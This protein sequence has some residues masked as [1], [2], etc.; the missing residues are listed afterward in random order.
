MLH[1]AYCKPFRKRPLR[2]WLTSFGT[3][4]HH[5]RVRWCMNSDSKSVGVVPDA[6]SL[7]PALARSALPYGRH[8]TISEHPVEI[9]RLTECC[10]SDLG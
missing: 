5:E 7:W 3:L 6:M 1:T 9:E 2:W 10:D 4:Q 8:H